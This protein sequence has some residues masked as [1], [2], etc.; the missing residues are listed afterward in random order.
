MCCYLSMLD[1]SFLRERFCMS[2]SRCCQIDYKGFVNFSESC[3]FSNVLPLQ[4]SL[5]C[6]KTKFS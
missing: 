6:F 4:F 1:L 2:S 3:S 5:E